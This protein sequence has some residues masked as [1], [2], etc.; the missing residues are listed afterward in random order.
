MK[1]G[2]KALSCC[3]LMALLQACGNRNSVKQV[4]DSDMI[5]EVTQLKGEH[6]DRG[7]FDY[8]VRLI[9][10][11]KLLAEKDKSYKNSLW[12]NM[13]SCF[14]IL[15]GQKKVYS[16]IIQPI[17]NGVNGTFEYML[18]FN[19]SDLKAGN[20]SLIYD[21]KYLDHKKYTLNLNE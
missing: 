14:Y 21:D 3:L 11:K 2:I 19:E 16:N 5:M 4:K 10:D 12:Y 17:A 13:D 20:W 8:A 18:S 9:P 1:N 15:N 6:A 7:T